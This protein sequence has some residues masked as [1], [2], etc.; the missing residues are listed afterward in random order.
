MTI[1]LG[2]DVNFTE[3]S[4]I[5]EWKAPVLHDALRAAAFSAWDGS[6]GDQDDFRK[7]IGLLK[8]LFQHGAN[9]NTIDSYGNNCL[10]RA[11]LD[12]RQRIASDSGFPD[13]IS[14][15]TLKRDLLEIFKILIGSGAN[16]HE[17]HNERESAVDF[18]TEPALAQ[19]LS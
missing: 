11:L 5:N 15:P 16:I 19:L 4:E 14:N 8:K 13:H 10:L 17:G 2:A 9:P 1:D 7:T 3:E 6:I 18:A 12:A